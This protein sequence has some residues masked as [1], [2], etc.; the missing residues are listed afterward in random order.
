MVCFPTLSMLFSP[1]SDN[2]P[3]QPSGTTPS[4]PNQIV[5]TN[6]CEEDEGGSSGPVISHHPTY[7]CCS[8]R[9]PA[10]P[11]SSF[12]PWSCLPSIMSVPQILMGLHCHMPL[13]Q[14]QITV[15]LGS[16]WFYFL[17][18]VPCFLI[19]SKTLLIRIN[20]YA[21]DGRILGLV[22][23]GKETAFVSQSSWSLLFVRLTLIFSFSNTTSLE[24]S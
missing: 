13:L 10:I 2:S 20:K 22:I 16:K 21:T 17:V 8:G 12:P 3:S 6:S 14:F 24:L 7:T 18:S 11:V 23:I 1:W 4:L 19:N 5:C 9:R 15:N